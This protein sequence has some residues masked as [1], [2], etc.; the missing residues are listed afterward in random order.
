[1]AF[2]VIALGIHLEI[3]CVARLDCGA[4][5]LF[6]HAIGR[7]KNVIC[8]GCDRKKAFYFFASLE[9]I[10]ILLVPNGKGNFSFPTRTVA[11]WKSHD[12]SS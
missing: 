6:G 10:G 7:T 11:G 8:D 12:A 9:N 5:W 2:A 3:M 4:E 1:L